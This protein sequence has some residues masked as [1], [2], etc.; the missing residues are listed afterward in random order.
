MSYP[1]TLHRGHAGVSA[2]SPACLL[3]AFLKYE[4]HPYPLGRHWHKITCRGIKIA[5]LANTHSAEPLRILSLLGCKLLK[6]TTE[7]DDIF[8]I[9]ITRYIRCLLDRVKIESQA[10]RLVFDWERDTTSFHGV[11]LIV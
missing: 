5:T 3:P 8:A 1:L 4:F 10:H 2:G 7:N 9:V 6:L 11:L